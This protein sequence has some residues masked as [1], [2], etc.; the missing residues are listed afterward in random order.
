MR[1]AHGGNAMYGLPWPLLHV[2][3]MLS[4]MMPSGM[5]AVR[6]AGAAHPTRGA[7]TRVFRVLS[8]RGTCPNVQ[9]VTIPADEAQPHEVHV[10]TLSRFSHRALPVRSISLVNTST[11]DVGGSGDDMGLWGR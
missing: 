5:R 11:V 7:G 4:Q 3:R 8:R 1:P 10:S 2:Q 6:D 9:K